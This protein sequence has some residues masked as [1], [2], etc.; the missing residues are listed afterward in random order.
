LRVELQTGSRLPKTGAIMFSFKTYTYPLEDI[1]A[2]GLA[3]QLADA[4]DGLGAGNAPG[5]WKVRILKTCQVI[6]IMCFGNAP[7]H[8]VG[9]CI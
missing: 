1:K 3:L 8:M 9:G 7:E 6:I 2:E 4:I 5:M